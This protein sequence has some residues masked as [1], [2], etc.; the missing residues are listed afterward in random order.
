MTHSGFAVA[1]RQKDI[2]R[3]TFQLDEVPAE[4]RIAVT[5]YTGYQL[6]LNGHKVYEEIGPWAQWTHPESLNVA[7]YMRKGQNVIAAWVQAYAGQNVHAEADMKALACVLSVRYQDGR[8][9]KLISDGTWRASAKEQEHWQDTD[10]DDA[11]WK[12]ATRWH[13]W[14]PSRGERN[15]W[16]TKAW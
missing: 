5:G 11:S 8:E 6:F 12:S 13:A 7:K 9:L 3:K 16:R 10:F 4:A 1:I 15:R 2:S 14:E